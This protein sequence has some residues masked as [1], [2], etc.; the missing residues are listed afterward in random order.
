[1][2]QK[3]NQYVQNL[4][5]ERNTSQKPAT[6]L[7]QHHKFFTLPFPK[8]HIITDPIKLTS[9]YM[10]ILYGFEKFFDLNFRAKGCAVSSKFQ[11]QRV[12]TE[13]LIILYP[14]NVSKLYVCKSQSKSEKGGGTCL[15]LQQKN[16]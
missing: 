12:Y 5:S 11:L 9:L 3:K 2:K 14:G 13:S 1:M 16:I 8:F 10:C 15:H 4:T 7:I 6:N